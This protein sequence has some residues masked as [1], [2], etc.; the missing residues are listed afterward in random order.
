MTVAS[1]SFTLLDEAV[2]LLKRSRGA[3]SRALARQTVRG[4]LKAVVREAGQVG[5]H[6]VRA[7]AEDL[8]GAWRSYEDVK[9][10]DVRNALGHLVAVSS[11]M[12]SLRVAMNA[13]GVESIVLVV[14]GCD[15]EEIIRTEI[16]SN[17]ILEQYRGKGGL[18]LIGHD[19]QT[20]V[21][22]SRSKTWTLRFPEL[23]AGQMEIWRD[24]SRRI[25]LAIARQW[26]KTLLLLC[27]ALAGALRGEDWW[28]AAPSFRIGDDAWVDCL[29]LVR[30]IGDRV[31]GVK[32]ELR[33]TFRVSFPSGGTLQ[34]V[35]SDDPD[36]L[37]SATKD[38]LVLDEAAFMSEDVWH[39]VAP[40]LAKRGGR[41][42]FAST[43]N[44]MNWF[45]DI[46]EAAERDGWSRYHHTTQEGGLVP[47]EAIEEA[48]ATY[49]PD[50]FQ[51][52]WE[53]VFT[54]ASA[55]LFHR[56]HL[57]HYRTE[58]VGDETVVSARRR[59]GPRP[60]V[61][62]LLDRRPRGLDE[63][64]RGFLGRRDVG[65]NAQGPSAAHRRDPRPPRGRRCHR[66][67]AVGAREARRHDLRRARDAEPRDRLD[68]E[69][70]E[71]AD[72]R[73]QGR[74]GQAL[75]GAGSRAPD[76]HRTHLVPA[77]AGRAVGDGPAG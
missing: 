41:A 42:L 59:D 14:R 53:A 47:L 24:P 72:Q 26:G 37:R 23:H 67:A 54:S 13:G 20:T 31:P 34:F 44:G 48:R 9:D 74:E 5:D 58:I 62:H 6:H 36:S 63:D 17:R 68:G 40:V 46:F 33:P 50:T 60:Y 32:V 3:R 25:V 71:P 1:D 57:Q 75:E 28:W 55:Q 49:P 45:H 69:T 2:A 29:R 65:R 52:E 11:S 10:G 12:A 76:G 64:E 39:V 77:P 73:R 21:R 70:R 51:R 8:E 43:P 7:L 4:A 30:A 38:G 18:E 56:E 35:S 22:R 19:G 61:P 16:A 15:D 66:G 27:T